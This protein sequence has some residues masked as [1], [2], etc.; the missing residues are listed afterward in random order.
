MVNRFEGEFG[1]YFT[2]DTLE[3]LVSDTYEDFAA[4]SKVKVHLPSFV[5]RTARQRLRALAKHEGHLTDHPPI[6]LFVCQRNDAA[7]QMA[8]ALFNEATGGRAEAM[9]AGASPAAAL[10]DEASHALYEVGIDLLGEHPKPLTREVEAG[11]DVIVTIDAHD[12]IDVLD[13]KEYHAWRL[14]PPSDG[15]IESYRA[16]RDELSGRVDELVAEVLE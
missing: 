8:A 4:R 11:A 14:P 6:V 2:R 16:M 3:H 15:G 10:L 7:S 13:D 1:A 12:D 5:E 9:S